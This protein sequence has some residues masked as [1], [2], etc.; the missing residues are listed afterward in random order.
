MFIFSWWLPAATQL[1]FL[2]G[3]VLSLIQAAAFRQPRLRAFLKITPLYKK[4]AARPTTIETRFAV[5]ETRAKPVYQAPTEASVAKEGEGVVG[6]VSREMREG[7]KSL[8]TT[9]WPQAGEKIFVS[10]EKAR[11][12]RLK[13]QADAYEK[14]RRAELEE[15]KRGR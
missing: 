15:R 4:P 5:R 10:Q 3:S 2:T 12:D 8:M 6:K 9:I 13:K 7:T 11:K 14:Q 1:T